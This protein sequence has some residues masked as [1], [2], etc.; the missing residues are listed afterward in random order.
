VVAKVPFFVFFI[1]L[2]QT[3]MFNNDIS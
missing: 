2:V 3:T 1:L